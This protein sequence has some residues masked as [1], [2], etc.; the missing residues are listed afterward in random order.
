MLTFPVNCVETAEEAGLISGTRAIFFSHDNVQE[1]EP[2]YH[3][4]QNKGF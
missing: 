1:K 3:W 2:G 4:P